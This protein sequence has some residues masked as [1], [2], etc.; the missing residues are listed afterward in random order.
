[1]TSEEAKRICTRHSKIPTFRPFI[2]RRRDLTCGHLGGEE[3]NN[4]FCYFLLRTPLIRALIESSV[5][6]KCPALIKISC[7]NDLRVLDRGPL[8]TGWESPDFSFDTVA[9]AA[10]YFLQNCSPL[11]IRSDHLK[12]L[13]AST[14]HRPLRGLLLYSS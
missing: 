6:E 14:N 13:K 10:H 8:C 9:L 12:H 3:L 7:K 5:P 4:A 2:V 1:M 11:H